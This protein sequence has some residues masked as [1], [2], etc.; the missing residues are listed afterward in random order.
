MPVSVGAE[1]Y[2]RHEAAEAHIGDHSQG[3]VRMTIFPSFAAF[4]V[5]FMETLKL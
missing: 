5:S 3:T 4:T 1:E 2:Q